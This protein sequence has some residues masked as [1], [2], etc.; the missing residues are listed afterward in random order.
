MFSGWY[1]WIAGALVGVAAGTGAKIAIVAGLRLV[2]GVIATLVAAA[3][4]AM[5][6]FGAGIVNLVR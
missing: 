6:G 2:S 3:G 1:H 4:G 5:I